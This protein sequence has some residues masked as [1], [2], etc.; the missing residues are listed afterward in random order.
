MAGKIYKAGMSLLVIDTENKFVS[1]G[2]A[3][4]IARVAQGWLTETFNIFLTR[5][6]N[7]YSSKLVTAGKYY[8]LPNASDA[9]ISAATKEALTSLKS[10]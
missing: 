4:E 5:K 9:V 1:T 2:F 6:T 10:S 8:Y 3:K 7:I